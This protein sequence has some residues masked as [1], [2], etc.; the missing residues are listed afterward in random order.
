M[1]LLRGVAVAYVGDSAAAALFKKVGFQVAAGVPY[2]LETQP[3]MATFRIG[4]FGL[5]KV[6]RCRL[7][8]SNP[9]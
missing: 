2:M 5:D 3:A 6:G 4:L 8:L 7:T 9:S 1:T